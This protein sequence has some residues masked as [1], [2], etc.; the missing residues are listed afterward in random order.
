MYPQLCQAESLFDVINIEVHDID[1]INK[2]SAHTLV[3][4][5][6]N[7]NQFHVLQKLIHINLNNISH[8]ALNT[9][10]LSYL[11]DIK[12]NVKL[13]ENILTPIL[14]ISEPTPYR[15]II[16]PLH[17]SSFLKVSFQINMNTTKPQ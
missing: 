3:E 14:S 12:T 8:F 2:V 7:N 13:P 17:Y 16:N 1:S 15:A 9:K 10:T 11:D 4:M 5:A 6:S